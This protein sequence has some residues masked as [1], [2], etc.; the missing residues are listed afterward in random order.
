MPDLYSYVLRD[1]FSF[2]IRRELC[3]L[4]NVNNYWRNII[5]NEFSEAP[6]LVFCS[7][8]YYSHHQSWS[9]NGLYP[10]RTTSYAIEFS[11]LV[12]KFIRFQSIDV[13]CA[14]MSHNRIVDFFKMSHVWI[15][16]N[17]RMYCNNLAISAE[18]ARLLSTTATLGVGVTE[19]PGLF[20]F[21]GEMISG[22]CRD[23]FISDDNFLPPIQVPWE[24]MIDHLFHQIDYTVYYCNRLF[25]ETKEHP[26]HAELLQFAH[27]VKERFIVTQ[28]SVMFFFSWESSYTHD[29]ANK[30]QFPRYDVRNERIE[31]ELKSGYSYDQKFVM[32]MT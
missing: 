17:L 19:E 3:H 2:C 31:R 12:P 30:L 21:L 22:K 23:V 8:R 26:I 7:L 27:D 20:R 25:I 18:Q 1:I 10:N 5:E 16:G 29:S 6:Y 11:Q 4:R 28:S 32:T 9:T 14:T 13:E 24:M 15:G